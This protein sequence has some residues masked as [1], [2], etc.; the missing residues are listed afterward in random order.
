MKKVIIILV[1]FL[2]VGCQEDVMIK[3]VKTTRSSGYGDHIEVNEII[4]DTYDKKG[5]IIQTE[6]Y[7]SDYVLKSISEKEYKGDLLVKV[8]TD[9]DGLITYSTRKYKKDKIIETLNYRKDKLVGKTTY[10]YSNENDSI[11]TMYDDKGDIYMETITVYEDEFHFTAK[12]RF[13]RD[14]L[15]SEILV[16]LNENGDIIESISNTNG[17]TETAIT[18]Y[19]DKGYRTRITVN[20]E[21]NGE[22]EYEYDENDNI[23][24]EI[25]KSKD[26][27]YVQEMEIVYW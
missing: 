26:F 10:E 23:I 15:E 19:N 18:E 4:I 14:D 22:F 13:L 1:M 24:K 12:S 5:R 8:T 16:V 21:T 2:L 6:K 11:M 7:T 3:E 17:E 25:F 27:I 9:Q 20:G